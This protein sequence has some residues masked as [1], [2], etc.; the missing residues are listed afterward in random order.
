MPVTQREFVVTSPLGKDVLLFKKEN[1]IGGCFNAQYVLELVVDFGG[2]AAYV[3]LATPV[4]RSSLLRDSAH[5]GEKLIEE[6]H[7]GNQQRCK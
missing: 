1:V 7:S 4:R 3:M 2:S 5:V 6:G